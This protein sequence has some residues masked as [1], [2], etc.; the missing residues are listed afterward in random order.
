M[1]GK[2]AD[3][4]CRE[5]KNPPLSGYILLTLDLPFNTH[6]H[7]LLSPPANLLFF[8]HGNRVRLF[9]PGQVVHVCA[10]ARV[11][12][13]ALIVLATMC[14]NFGVYIHSVTL[15]NILHAEHFRNSPRFLGPPL[16]IYL[17]VRP[18][19]AP[20]ASTSLFNLVSDNSHLLL[21]F[22]SV[23]PYQVPLVSH[24]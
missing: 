7:F 9:R 5:F 14:V 21:I 4:D 8:C 2:V 23:S 12:G 19:N 17:Y 6:S 24:P 16:Y 3:R 11:C 20:N 1:R 15:F 18:S 13:C 10:R 22:A